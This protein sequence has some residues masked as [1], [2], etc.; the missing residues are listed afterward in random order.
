MITNIFV[1]FAKYGSLAAWVISSAQNAKV[2]SILLTPMIMVSRTTWC[3]VEGLSI[4][5]KN[6]PND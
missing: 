6:K 2:A 1:C 3:L 5:T 4:G